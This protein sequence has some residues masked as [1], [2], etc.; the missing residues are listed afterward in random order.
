[1][2]IFRISESDLSVAVENGRRVEREQLW[3]SVKKKCL[4]NISPPKFFL[5]FFFYSKKC[6]CWN[7]S[8]TH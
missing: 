7:F 5:I 8:G 4:E 2:E 1:M 6:P 3:Y